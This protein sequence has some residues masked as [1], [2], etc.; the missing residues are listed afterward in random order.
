MIRFLL[1]RYL[2]V[3]AAANLLWESIQ[4]PLY[5]IAKNGSVATQAYAVIHCTLGDVLIAIVS[6]ATAVAVF[7]LTQ[8]SE[9]SVLLLAWALS[10][11]YTVFSEWFNTNIKLAWQYADLMPTILGIGLSPL[12]QWLVVPPLSYLIAER[13]RRRWKRGRQT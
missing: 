7:R 3:F 5:T 13:T 8:R 6:F 4:L 11:S 12:L 10:I 1:T 2:P 9:R